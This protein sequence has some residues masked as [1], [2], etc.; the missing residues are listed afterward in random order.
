MR[1]AD[2]GFTMP[3]EWARHAGCWMAWPKRVELWR[4]HLEAARED[5][6]R[7]ARAIAAY[8][9]LTMIAHPEQAAEAG[10]RCGPSIRVVTSHSHPSMRSRLC[11]IS[12]ASKCFAVRRA[13]SSALDPKPAPYAAFSLRPICIPI[14]YTCA[15]SLLDCRG[16]CSTGWRIPSGKLHRSTGFQ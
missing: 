4:E 3:A 12:S 5:Y 13:R 15:R 2:L 7:V 1:P 14:R 9:P 6:I 8:E 11:S 16:K 10:R